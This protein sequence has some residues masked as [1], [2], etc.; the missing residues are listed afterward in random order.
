V[1]VHIARLTDLQAE[2]LYEDNAEAINALPDHGLGFSKS[3]TEEPRGM[4]VLVAPEGV[5][6]KSVLPDV[7]WDQEAV[8]TEQT[9][10]EQPAQVQALA[11]DPN[12]GHQEETD[13]AEQEQSSGSGDGASAGGEGGFTFDPGA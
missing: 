13:H 8:P 10:Q 5:D 7:E 11:E 1:T 4:L 6:P 3:F 9:T 2:R 12:P